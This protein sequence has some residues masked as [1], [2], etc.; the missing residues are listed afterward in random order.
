MPVL[1]KFHI[2]EELYCK[3]VG[4]GEWRINDIDLDTAAQ[5]RGHFGADTSFAMFAS[6][7]YFDPAVVKPDTVVAGID[8][9]RIENNPAPQEV[10]YPLN[11]YH[12]VV[13]SKNGLGYPVFDCGPSGAI[14]P[15]W[16][17]LDDLKVYMENI[18][19]Q[20]P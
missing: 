2:T 7:A 18:G 20:S 19:E 6:G 15:H 11:V 8:W 3:L 12:Y 1:P 10:N 5:V 16:A 14:A 4:N 13:G 17:T 9:V